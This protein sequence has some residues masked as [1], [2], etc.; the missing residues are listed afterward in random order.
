VLERQIAH[1]KARG[2]CWFATHAEI[3][4]WCKENAS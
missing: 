4:R 3:A 1:A 2:G